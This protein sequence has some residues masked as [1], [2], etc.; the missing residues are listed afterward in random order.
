M[1]YADAVLTIARD[2]VATPMLALGAGLIS[3]AAA[4]GDETDAT[5][6][7]FRRCTGGYCPGCGGSRAAW[8]LLRGDIARSW[9]L[10]PWVSVLA[11]QLLVAAVAALMIGV[12]PLRR[13][14][15]VPALAANLALGIAIWIARLASGAIPIPFS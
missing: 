13:R 6:C 8:A 2:R 7:L 4:T 10:H 15:L 14:F 12:G 5:I 3:I 1:I 9:A 11:I